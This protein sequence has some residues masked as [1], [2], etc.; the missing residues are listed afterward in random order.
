MAEL[1]TKPTNASVKLFLGSIEDHEK[2]E[3]A[4]RLCKIMRRATAKSC[5]YLNRLGDVE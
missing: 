1:K 3:D 4:E 2:R 5:L